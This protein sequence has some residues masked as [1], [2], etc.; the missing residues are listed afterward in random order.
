ML[1]AAVNIE[2]DQ[3]ALQERIKEEVQKQ[4]YFQA[5]LTDVETLCEITC[6]SKR[7]LE[8]YILSD[9]RVHQ[10]L[11]RRDRKTF[12]LYEPTIE[13]IKQIVDEWGN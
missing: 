8:D 7:F 3:Q 6:M 11:R 12:Y 13:A 9:P 10:H 5:L 1:P 4:V 2:I